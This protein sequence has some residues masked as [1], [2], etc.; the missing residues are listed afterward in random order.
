MD[1]CARPVALTDSDADATS[2]CFVELRARNSDPVMGAGMHRNILTVSER[3]CQCLESGD[4]R[5]ADLSEHA[6]FPNR[7]GTWLVKRGG[8]APKLSS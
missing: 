7:L 8:R 5:P 3:D 4:P 2:V 6:P 1:S